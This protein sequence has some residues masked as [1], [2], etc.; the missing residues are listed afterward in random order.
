MTEKN[1]RRVTGW[2]LAIVGL[3]AAVV[4]LDRLQWLIN[5]ILATITPF[6]IAYLLA[7]ILNPMIT[8]MERRGMRR[9]Y[10]V[11]LTSLLFLM[12]FAGAILLL[13]PQLIQ[14]GADL[15]K[16]MPRF[17]RTVQDSTNQFLERAEPML[18]RFNLPTTLPGFAKRFPVE[19]RGFSSS[20]LNSLSGFILALAGRLTWLVIVPIVTIWLLMNWDS[21]REKFQTLLPDAHRDRIMNVLSSVGHV[22]DSYVRGALTLAVL[23]G[24]LTSLMLGLIFRMPYALVLG[25][26]AALA[27][28]IPYIGSVFILLTTGIVAYAANP[29]FGYVAAVIGAVIVLNNGLFDNF[30]SP[31][32]LGGFAGLSL[33]W[34][35]FALLLGGSLFGIAGMILAVPVGA[36]INILL[37]EVFP[38][39]AE[40]EAE[41]PEEKEDPPKA[42]E[43]PADN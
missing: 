16:D 20:V 21:Q 8:R 9:A 36:T 28:P 27:S 33:P 39:I 30:L 35:I 34:S 6:A 25:L 38:K 18:K 2:A 4:L 41:V 31:R 24:V 11:A 43:K 42:D 15:A 19:L 5:P 32:V 7:L 13:V 10:S 40:A 1:W 29:S 3:L 12:L 14:Q 17:A 26:V 23:Y 37:R 22:L